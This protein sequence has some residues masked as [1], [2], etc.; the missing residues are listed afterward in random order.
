MTTVRYPAPKM[1]D[2]KCQW[3]KK[4]FQARSADVKR[5]WGLFCS[6]SCKA[7]KQE[8]RTGQYDRLL[9]ENDGE[10]PV[11]YER[12]PKEYQ[13]EIDHERALYESTSDHG[14]DNTSAW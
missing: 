2:R 12:L 6:K 13:R 3:C 8:K 5:G 9:R 14:Q 1:V 7:I 11:P 10:H 4:P